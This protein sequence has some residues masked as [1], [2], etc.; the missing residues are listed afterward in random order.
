VNADE[1][2][3]ALNNRAEEFASWL[4]PSGKLN[5]SEWQVGSL[6]GEGGKSCCIRIRGSKAGIFK[7]FATDEA[8]DNLVELFA[9]SRRVEFKEAL[10]ACAD[11]LGVSLRS[12]ETLPST[13]IS[14]RSPVTAS[15]LP[16]PMS[17]SD[18]G[19]ALA[20]AATLRDDPALC[21]RI[22]RARNWQKE[23]ILTLACEPSLGW[24]GG[25]LAF[26]YESGTKLRWRENG[27]RVIRWAFGKPWLWRGGF[28]WGRTNI[29]VT[30]GETDCITLIDAGI[31]K[32]GYSLAVALPSAS[33]FN[34]E[35]AH[36]FQGKDVVLVLDGD[37][38]GRGATA[39]ISR[40]LQ[41]VTKSLKQ[42]NWGG[43]R[44][45]G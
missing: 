30:E 16:T 34:E 10:R 11:W 37:D 5:G 24:D 2:K 27:E 22:A 28:L 7:D 32:D 40:L 23:T 15:P 3:T 1:V 26:L 21:E 13:A 33:T 45:A 25:K 6:N 36:L 35:W 44:H 43:L 38:A 19:R 39:R 12:N 18:S 29:Y 4:F 31:E 9:Q 41:P 20:M 17:S 42:L 8:G 14:S